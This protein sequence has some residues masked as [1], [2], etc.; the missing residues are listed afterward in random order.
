MSLYKDMELESRP[1]R[2]ESQIRKKMRL[3]HQMVKNF[4]VYIESA[5]LR[6]THHR[7]FQEEGLNLQ[8]HAWGVDS[9][10]KLIF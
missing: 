4:H 1:G 8:T 10:T 5:Y 7:V 2:W 3:D 6:T 9:G